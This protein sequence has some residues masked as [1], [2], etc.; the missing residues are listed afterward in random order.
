M[1][2]SLE[3]ILFQQRRNSYIYSISVKTLQ[4]KINLWKP[5]ILLGLSDHTRLKKRKNM[6]I[7]V[8]FIHINIYNELSRGRA[9]VNTYKPNNTLVLREM[10]QQRELRFS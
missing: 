3:I 6:L 7:I 5:E 1:V 2:I 9:Y 4:C 8:Q 10:P